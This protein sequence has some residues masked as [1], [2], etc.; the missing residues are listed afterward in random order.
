MTVIFFIITTVSRCMCNHNGKICYPT[1]I[2][3]PEFYNVILAI[4]ISNSVTVTYLP[5][6]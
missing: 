5:N 3:P 1:S 6:V 2:F 4:S